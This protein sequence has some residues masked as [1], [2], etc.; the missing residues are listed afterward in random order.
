MASS[1]FKKLYESSKLLTTPSSSQPLP[2]LKRD[3]SQIEKETDSMTKRI[4]P[5]Q[6][7][8]AKAH[9]FLA[10]GGI[11]SQELAQN[12]N[13]INKVSTTQREEYI[14]NTN[15]EGYL[16]QMHELDIIDTIEELRQQTDD[17]VD[18]LEDNMFRDD[19]KHNQLRIKEAQEMESHRS[20]NNADPY[21]HYMN[22]STTIKAQSQMEEQMTSY[23]KVV[24]EIND[25]RKGNKDYPV[26][27][28][29]SEAMKVNKP[30]TSIATTTTTAAA[31]ATNPMM[32]NAI[33]GV[34]AGNK[35][36]RVKDIWKLLDKLAGESEADVNDSIKTRYMKTYLVSPYDSTE[37]LCSRQHLI[38][39]SKAWLED[40]SI[41]FMDDSLLK[42]AHEVKPGGNPSFLMRLQSFIKLT[43]KKSNQ[44]TDSRLEIVDDLPVWTYI[45][46]ALRSGQDKLALEY[47]QQ[48]PQM[49]QSEPQF[50]EYLKE[51]ISNPNQCLT[52]ETRDKVMVIYQ[53]LEFSERNV[54]PYKLILIKI[55]GRCELNKKNCP[56]VI[57][58][59][60][61]Y[62]WL[63]LTLIRENLDEHEFWQEK[64]TLQDLQQLMIKY[65]ATRFDPTGTTPWT[66]F[67]VLLS[68]LQFEH[69]INYLYKNEQ[70][71]LQAIHFAIAL[72]YYG[73]LRI[74]KEPLRTSIDLLIMEDNN[75]TVTLN[76]T[77]MIYQY[78]HH[79]IPISN[80]VETDKRNEYGALSTNP[81]ATVTKK[82]KSPY[83][84][85]YP[86]NSLHYLL[87]MSLY[88]TRNGYVNNNMVTLARSYVRDLILS[89]DDYKYLLGIPRPDIGKQPGYMDSYSRLL[90]MENEQEYIR[91]LLHPLA[92]NYV[93]RGKYAEAIYNYELSGD[94]NLAVDILNHQLTLAL[95]RHSQ[96]MEDGE[97][98]TVSEMI[99]FTQS[100]LANYE[101]HQHIVQMV[102]DIKKRT[103]RVL[104]EF[105][106]GKQYYDQN[107]YDKALQ[108]I[109]QTG[110]IPT[111]Y[112]TDLLQI[113]GQ[114]ENLDTSICNSM[115]DVL[116]MTMDML[117]RMWQGYTNSDDSLRPVLQTPIETIEKKV[118]NLLVFVGMIRLKIS[119]D[120]II[121]LNRLEMNMMDRRN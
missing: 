50:V 102:S 46:M 60:E 107:D 11:N 75:N 47:I 90:E 81:A 49:F 61:D 63:Q 100:T 104:I 5:N 12:L 67:K 34:M 77:R 56:D 44:W 80:N 48:H 28:A 96:S 72:M 79:S 22:M 23:A 62:L 84:K 91:C 114:F 38:K 92:E 112:S 40:Q 2:F 105:V 51:Y 9:Y 13:A 4:K 57:K 121:K 7:L 69:A 115:P 42:Y 54:D 68:T 111:D 94:Y 27:K 10:Q 52:K 6:Q 101:Q 89:T 82:Q 43:Y 85:Q 18:T 97:R 3:V 31:A 19:M 73:L 45:F 98:M 113:V 21:T 106:R 36:H 117:Y 53:R 109:G 41:Q 93:E 103:V 95:R 25:K 24:M 83:I 26:I 120:I 39:C 14:S 70:T 88:S 78:I 35:D 37:A 15:V 59:T 32:A 66:Y 33:D 116:V 118:R 55:L 99:Q 76:F 87:L 119:S 64:Y 17:Y 20:N 1:A 58:T 30:D 86:I 29:F 71:R 110:V 16:A 74:P 65:G 8:H 108:V